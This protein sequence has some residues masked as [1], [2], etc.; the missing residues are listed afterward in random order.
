[1]R[2]QVAEARTIPVAPATIAEPDPLP[3]PLPPVQDMATTGV[4]HVALSSSQQNA[5]NVYKKQQIESE[6]A[7]YTRMN[8]TYGDIFIAAVLHILISIYMDR[9]L[10]AECNCKS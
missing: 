4:L 1:M 8:G 2:A 5:L 9:Y 6:K 10:Y 3:L 7:L